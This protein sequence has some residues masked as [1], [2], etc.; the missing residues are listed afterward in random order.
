MK[1][2][3]AVP[4]VSPFVIAL[5]VLLMLILMVF[6]M[7]IAWNWTWWQAW[8]YA[9]LIFV[10]SV[11]SRI[12]AARINPAIIQERAKA[13]AA[14]TT[15]SW[16]KPIV[17]LLTIYLPLL[18][19]IIA[20]LDKRFGWSPAIPLVWQIIAILLIALGYG[21]LGTWAM[22]ANTYFSSHVRIQKDRGQKVIENGPYR[23]VRHPGY[24][25]GLC[26]FL[27]AP[28][29]LQSYWALTIAVVYIVVLV[30]RTARED[31]TLQD[32]LPGYKEYSQ[33]TRFRLLP[34]VW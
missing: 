27:P 12:L 11:L 16:D 34:G 15:K 7:A 28:I 13:F 2:D 17:G 21:V 1:N 32:E 4:N 20:G 33:K 24:L 8:V 14:T 22:V 30:Y 3:R 18:M 6:P 10:P 26:A 23:F 31:K 29:L 9:F 25:G 19:C 5:R